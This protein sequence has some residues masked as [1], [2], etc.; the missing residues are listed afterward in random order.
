[1]IKFNNDQIYIF[2][3]SPTI[4]Q[5]GNLFFNPLIQAWQATK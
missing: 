4:L 2:M 3:L 1:M 5:R